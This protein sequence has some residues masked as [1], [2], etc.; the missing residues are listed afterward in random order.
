V[1]DAVHAAYGWN[2]VTGVTDANDTEMLDRR[3]FN[4]RSKQYAATGRPSII[5]DS[6]IG[7]WGSPHKQDTK[8]R[9][10]R[11]RWAKKKSR[12]TKRNYGW[13]EDA[14]FLVPDGVYERICGTALASARQAR[15]APM[16]GSAKF[17]SDRTKHT[18]PELARCKLSLMEHR[19]LPDGL[20]EE[21]LPSFSRPTPKA[22]GTRDSSGKGSRTLMAQKCAVAD[23]RLGR[24]GALDQDASDFRRCAGDFLAES[25]GG[26][27]HALRHPGSTRW[28]PPF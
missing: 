7:L 9:A 17:D 11:S 2:V 16:N 18:F 5:V 21:H 22:M 20:G 10:R 8:R 3:G 14:K 15:C 19:E 13:P 1:G 25:H 26:R 12:L 28:P 24:S 23:G 6:H 27:K 4:V